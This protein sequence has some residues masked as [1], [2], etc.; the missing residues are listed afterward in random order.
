MLKLCVGSSLLIVI[1]I[2]NH[3]D[4]A[5]ADKVPILLRTMLK[6]KQALIATIDYRKKLKPIINIAILFS[7]MCRRCELKVYSISSTCLRI[8]HSSIDREKFHHLNAEVA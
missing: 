4:P 1:M 8:N 2:P 7:S 3:L 6:S 5:G